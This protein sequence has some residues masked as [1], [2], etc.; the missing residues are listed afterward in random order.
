MSTTCPND[1]HRPLRLRASHDLHL[2]D[3][4]CSN[5][6]SQFRSVTSSSFIKD[7]HPHIITIVKDLL[8][9]D[10]RHFKDFHPKQKFEINSF[11]TLANRY[12]RRY[13]IKCAPPKK[14]RKSFIYTIRKHLGEHV[15]MKKQVQKQLEREFT[16]A[17]LDVIT[18]SW[19][20]R[21]FFFFWL[22]FLSLRS[23]G[24]RVSFN[25]FMIKHL[26]KNYWK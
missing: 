25:F 16:L 3:F 1:P 2:I 7:A 10:R 15:T 9:T 20:S 17:I 13:F 6:A 21:F 22:T 5:R 12:N 14:E 24:H 4:I 23:F 18:Q 11:C 8:S 19:R 26:A